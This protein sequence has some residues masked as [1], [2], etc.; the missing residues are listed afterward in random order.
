YLSAGGAVFTVPI[1]TN[2]TITGTSVTADPYYFTG[3]ANTYIT[4]DAGDTVQIITGGTERFEIDS[5]EATFAVPIATTGIS[6]P[7]GDAA[8]NFDGGTTKKI[9]YDDS[10]T[11]IELDGLGLKVD[12][13]VGIGV[14]PSATRRL[15][16]NDTFTGTS[17][18]HIGFGAFQYAN[19]S[20]TSS[21][22]TYGF[23]GGAAVYTGNAQNFTGS[24]RGLQGQVEHRGSGIVAA[25]KGVLGEVFNRASDPVTEGTITDARAFQAWT[26][27]EDGTIV[28]GTH[29][30][31]LEPAVDTGTLTD[32]YHFYATPTDTVCE[33]LY[34][35]YLGAMTGGTVQNWAIYSA[36]GDSYFAGNFEIAGIT[37]LGDG[38]NETQFAADGVQT[39]AGNARVIN[40]IILEAHVFKLPAA[41]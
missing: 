4:S 35:L 31:S 21:A 29:F 24:L 13:D 18:F 40:H 1:S 16:I 32:F 15:Y 38:T 11:H 20:G 8:I 12:G 27:A 28:T 25:A 2:S 7:S 5:A 19:P 30:Y 23:L 41:N 10:E 34:G 9:L 3:D 33:D 37:S 17:G 36:G 26:D 14:S 22:I 6:F 39:M